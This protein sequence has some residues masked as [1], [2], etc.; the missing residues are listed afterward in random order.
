[1]GGARP[2]QFDLPLIQRFAA[3]HQPVRGRGGDNEGDAVALDA[4][5]VER[6]GPLPVGALVD[7]PNELMIVEHEKAATAA[8]QGVAVEWL[9]DEIAPLPAAAQRRPQHHSHRLVALGVGEALEE[10]PPEDQAE[11]RRRNA[12][13]FG[14]ALR[15]RR[16]RGAPADGEGEGGA[17]E[18]RNEELH[19]CPTRLLQQGALLPLHAV[20]RAGAE[21]GRVAALD[22]LGV[23]LEHLARMRGRVGRADAGGRKCTW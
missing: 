22:R 20:G 4:R 18:R 2:L 12:A 23:A 21:P 8:R 7:V 13:S 10:A 19:S 11:R 6:E 1:L 16:R 3:Q 17:L 9:H 5:A 15:E 14:Q